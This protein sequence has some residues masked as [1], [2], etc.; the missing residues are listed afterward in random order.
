VIFRSGFVDVDVASGI[1]RIDGRCVAPSLDVVSVQLTS[2]TGLAPRLAA[3]L[4]YAGWWITGFVIWFVE[5]RDTYVRFHAAQSITAF[6]LIALFIGAFSAFAVASLSFLPSA[7]SLFI[8]AAG[9]TWIGG[10]ILWAIS[11][12]KAGNGEPWRIPIAAELA[13]R[14][15]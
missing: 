7:F 11:M 3:P 5:R 15:V 2:S 10:L 12:W 4:A 1:S 6:G 13:D 14:M 8:W 9:L